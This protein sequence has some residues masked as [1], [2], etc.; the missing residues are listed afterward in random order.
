MKAH[1]MPFANDDGARRDVYLASL[2]I[3]NCAT[4]T[5]A[6]SLRSFYDYTY[7]TNWAG[8]GI[9]HIGKFKMLQSVKN[10]AHCACIFAS[11]ARLS[12]IVVATTKFYLG[13]PLMLR[14]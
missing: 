12:I 14:N 7:Y 8:C 1:F 2:C 11:L 4:T 6:S 10:N 13:G 5:F 9:I 3:A